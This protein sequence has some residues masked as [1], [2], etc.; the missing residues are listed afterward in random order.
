[1]YFAKNIDDTLHKVRD[2]GTS[3]PVGEDDPC[4]LEWLAD[5]GVLGEM[6]VVPGP[7]L[8][9]AIACAVTK[10]R[11]ACRAYIY[12]FYSQEKQN[13]IVADESC[14]ATAPPPALESMYTHDDFVRYH[15]FKNEA[16]VICNAACTEIQ[17][18]TSP[19]AVKALLDE[20]IT[21]YG[22]EVGCTL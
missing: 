10:V 20:L 11:A 7:T 14:R 17:A 9:E 3:R 5:G 1:M 8:E 22:G 12:S 16:R 4:Y 6:P 13:N 18:T 21:L 2:D 15:E 19:E